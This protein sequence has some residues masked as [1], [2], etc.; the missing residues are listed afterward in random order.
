MRLVLPMG[1][2]LFLL[3]ALLVA[4]VA[5]FPLRLALGAAG[6]GLSARA[7]EG[8]VWFGRLEEARVR[9]LPLGDVHLRASV[10][11][12]LVGDLRFDVR[13]D[14]VRGTVVAGSGVTDV[15]GRIVDLPAIGGVA[16]RALD[17]EGVTALFRDG[18]CAEARG[19]VRAVPAA[20]PTLEG[21]LR[22]DGGALLAPLASPSGRERIDLRLS[23]DGTVSLAGAASGAGLVSA[24]ASGVA[25]AAPVPTVP[26]SGTAE[27]MNYRLGLKAERNGTAIRGYR[28][29][30]GA[31]L[32][33]L[34]RAG[35]R[36]GDVL[37]SVNGTAIADEE[38]LLELPA[39]MAAASA[40]EIEYE[41]DGVRARATI[42]GAP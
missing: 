30:P 32:P 35:L 23:P 14:R 20:G 3:A 27:L 16:L 41:R 39:E 34:A 29:A 2:G 11:P 28:I 22:C 25:P 21:A 19:R 26:G 12:L 13:G 9:D 4:L 33:T 37:L 18:R 1:R 40:I 38:R 31:D 17:L 8:S 24:P 42:P 10:L 5:L 6:D 7:V 36:P 15:D